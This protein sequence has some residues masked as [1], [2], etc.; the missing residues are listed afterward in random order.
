MMRRVILSLASSV[1]RFA[2]WLHGLAASPEELLLRDLFGEGLPH[3]Q[4]RLDR[5]VCCND[6]LARHLEDHHS[7]RGCEFGAELKAF[8]GEALHDR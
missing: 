6:A 4:R 3:R 5:R 8:S 2:D 1:S 7:V